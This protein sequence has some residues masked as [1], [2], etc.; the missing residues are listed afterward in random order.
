MKRMN[1]FDIDQVGISAAR[2]YKGRV[3]SPFPFPFLVSKSQY[4]RVFVCL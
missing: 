4:I 1:D 3:S 2:G